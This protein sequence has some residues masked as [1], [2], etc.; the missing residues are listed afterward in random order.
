MGQLEK[1]NAGTNDKS[2]L[3]IPERRYALFE[4]LIYGR[5]ALVLTGNDMVTAPKWGNFIKWIG[6]VK[7]EEIR[8]IK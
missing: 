6:P 4:D 8:K 7:P 1:T 2:I 5:Y 3:L